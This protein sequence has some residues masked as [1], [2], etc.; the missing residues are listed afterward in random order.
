MNIHNLYK[1]STKE[2][3]IH[4]HKI[5]GGL[6]LA[7]Y[8][9]RYYL[10]FTTGTMSLHTDG[11]YYMVGVHG[12]LSCSSMI[13]HIPKKR[14]NGGPMIY[15]EYRLHSIAFALRSVTCYYLT[16]HQF[17]KIWNV[18]VCF[19]TMF[20]ADWVSAY[21][22]SGTTT[23]RQMPFA[24]NVESR[25]RETIIT[26]Q[27]LHQIAATLYMVGN[28]DA[29]FSP[30]FAIQFAAFLMTLV[31]KSIISANG[32]HILYNFSLWINILCYWSLPVNYIVHHMVLTQVFY[33]WRFRNRDPEKNT[34]NLFYGNKY[35]GWI[36]IFVL[37]FYSIQIYQMFSIFDNRIFYLLPQTYTFDL[38]SGVFTLYINEWWFRVLTI[39]GYCAYTAYINRVLF[40]PVL[41]RIEF[42]NK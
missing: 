17:S 29:C 37:F 33:Y 28:E 39:M 26:I 1:L 34:H 42:T 31:R 8:V 5:L 11:A 10:L 23:M 30:M 4:L 19:G 14:I 38:N 16:Y 21:F 40:H 15:P 41:F 18:G 22:P 12:L 24:N 32:W 7:H 35:V 3:P 27:S 13:F 25:D 9:Y 20:V 2:D 6:C 36:G